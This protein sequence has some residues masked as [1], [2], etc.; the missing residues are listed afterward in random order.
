MLF[1]SD[2]NFIVSNAVENILAAPKLPGNNNKDYLK[3]KNYGKVPKYLQ[4][5]KKE[6]E[7]KIVR[8]AKV[9]KKGLDLKNFGRIDFFLDESGILY[10]NEVNSIP[11]MTDGSIFPEL[12][13]HSGKNTFSE[14]ITSIIDDI[15]PLN[16]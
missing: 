13:I 14:I 15:I 9:I 4:T 12:W 6:I 3:K 16:I 7:E 2:K 5:I 11:G 8:Y 1:R 10:F